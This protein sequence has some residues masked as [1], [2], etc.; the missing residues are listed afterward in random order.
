MPNCSLFSSTDSPVAVMTSG[1]PPAHAAITKTT[2]NSKTCV[3]VFSKATSLPLIGG[4][5]HKPLFPS[6][7]PSLE[8]KGTMRVTRN[9]VTNRYLSR[10][11]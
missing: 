2:L 10:M 6:S 1:G 7:F 3:N 8:A 9:A 11:M 5:R 4:K